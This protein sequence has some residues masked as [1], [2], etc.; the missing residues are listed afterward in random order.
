MAT[1][2]ADAREAARLARE[3]AA[4]QRKRNYRRARLAFLALVAPIVFTFCAII[5]WSGYWSGWMDAN[6]EKH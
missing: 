4:E 5:Y 2:L 1:P 6:A 3:E